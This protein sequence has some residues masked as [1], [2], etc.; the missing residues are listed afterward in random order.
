MGEKQAGREGMTIGR[1]EGH[2]TAFV[3]DHRRAI[4]ALVTFKAD[5]SLSLTLEETS[6]NHG[7]AI[8]LWE[9][10]VTRATDGTIDID[11]RRAVWDIKSWDE[12]AIM[13]EI[14]PSP[15]EARELAAQLSEEL[16]RTVR[17]IPDPGES[18]PTWL[19]EAKR[20]AQKWADL[21]REPWYVYPDPREKCGWHTS[22]TAEYS[23]LK[24]IASVTPT[25][26]PDP[27]AIFRH[28][29]IGTSLFDRASGQ[30]VGTFEG[31]AGDTVQLKSRITGHSVFSS[32]LSVS[33]HQ[34]AAY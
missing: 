25:P 20:D 9:G 22:N 27:L 31:I 17:L 3:I 23:D 13:D 18:D 19:E 14:L 24:P 5:G 4:G 32:G 30:F 16:G 2:G 33:P 1:N 21:H 12:A 26:K 11:A 6:D 10:K 8:V 29:P 28:L 15:E 7:P 34:G